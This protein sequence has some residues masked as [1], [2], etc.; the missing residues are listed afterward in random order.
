LV[1][2]V[3]IV[4]APA[5]RAAFTRVAAIDEQHRHASQSCF[6]GDELA[7]LTE[8]PVVQPSWLAT[9]L[10]WVADMGQILQPN[11]AHGA[12]SG[13]NKGL[14]DHMVVVGLKPQFSFR[15]L[16]QPSLGSLGAAALKTRAPTQ[17]M[18]SDLLD[19]CSSIG[20]AVA[21]DCDGDDA[22]VNA[23]QPGRSDQSGNNDVTPAG[24]VHAA[25]IHQINVTVRE[26]KRPPLILSSV[27]G[28]LLSAGNLFLSSS[29]ELFSCA[30]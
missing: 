5:A 7:E 15:E 24:D 18:G 6:R 16:A 9:G 19:S 2:S 26:G 10:N 12:L 14:P 20:F 8:R 13:L 27:A 30:T 25:D 11:G 23:E 4:D 1:W 21:V 22:E 3:A 28:N 17:E 29:I